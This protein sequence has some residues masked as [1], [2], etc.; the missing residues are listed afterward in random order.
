MGKWEVPRG[1]GRFA[2]GR[3]GLDGAASPRA[4]RPAWGAEVV[5]SNIVGYEKIPLGAN[6]MDILACQFVDVGEVAGAVNIQEIVPGGDFA[7]DGG[8]WIKVYNPVTHLY[9]TAYY[10][11][12]DADGIFDP[13]DTEYEN[14]LGAGWGDGEQFK[15]DFDIAVGKGFWSQ[16]VAGGSITV[17]GQV[18]SS[19]TITLNS[20]EM[21]LFA[22]PLPMAVNIQDV[23]PG[24]NFATDGGDWIK[25]YNP[26]TH[27]YT[28]AYYFG[29]DADGIFDPTDTEYENSLGA[30]WGDGEQF[31]LDFEIAGGQ[32]F[33]AQAV[34]GGTLAF[35]AAE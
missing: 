15:L 16:A 25:V 17:A 32:G 14:S 31:K 33:W 12:E 5:S 24:G 30:G 10:F 9:T 19:S 6:T 23:I 21:D 22:N 11:G 3:G 13:T 20:N 2:L 1:P 35:P 4:T 26:A 18:A 27:L 7:T 8:D 28:T 34:E 29:E